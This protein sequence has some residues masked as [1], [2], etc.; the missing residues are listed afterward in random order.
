MSHSRTEMI[1]F[2]TTN[3]P[4]VPASNWK[5]YSDEEL[6]TYVELVK[7]SMVQH[8][9]RVLEDDYVAGA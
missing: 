5:F 9:Q 8:M 6:G 4:E 1:Q 3:R 2:L 7:R